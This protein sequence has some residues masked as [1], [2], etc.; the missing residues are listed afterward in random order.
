MLPTWQPAGHALDTIRELSLGDHGATLLQQP[1]RA[2][3]SSVRGMC[4][5]KRD[6]QD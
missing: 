5:V 4:K 6:D 2:L 1:W 3:G